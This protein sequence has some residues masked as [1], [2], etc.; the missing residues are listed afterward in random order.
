VDVFDAAIFEFPREAKME[1]GEVG[2][3]SEGGFPTLGFADE[4]THCSYQR[5]QMT[6]NFGY[7][8]DGDLGIVGD[9]VDASGAHLRPPHAEDF[10][11][12][13]LLQGGGEARGVHV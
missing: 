7:A 8:N 1:S 2:E 4:A 5:R 6:E 13:A 12:V 9:D 3:D 10:F 11:V